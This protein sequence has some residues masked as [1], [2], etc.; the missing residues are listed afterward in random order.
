MCA[1]CQRSRHLQIILASSFYDF[2]VSPVSP[3]FMSHVELGTSIISRPVLEGKAPDM[4]SLQSKNPFFPC[5]NHIKKTNAML[6]GHLHFAL[7][8]PANIWE[9]N[10]MASSSFAA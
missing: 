2:H 3:Y 5:K 8:D 6:C 1:N 7:L 4:P 10:C 9:E